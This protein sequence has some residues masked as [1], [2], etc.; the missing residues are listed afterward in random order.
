MEKEP[1]VR[2]TEKTEG[3]I[4]LH[5]PLFDQS[6]DSNLPKLCSKIICTSVNYV[7]IVHKWS[8]HALI[9]LW[10]QLQ[11]QGFLV[12]HFPFKE[13]TLRFGE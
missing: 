10:Q 6:D 8:V 12:D 13:D 5:S 3:T 11:S 9:R 2:G 4:E 7:C 1:T